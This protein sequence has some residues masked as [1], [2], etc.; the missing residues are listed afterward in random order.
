MEG[1]SPR[2]G[3][4]G[5]PTLVNRTFLCI[6][7]KLA[8]LPSEVLGRVADAIESFSFECIQGKLPP[9]VSEGIREKKGKPE[10][11]FEKANG[12]L[13]NAL[14]CLHMELDCSQPYFAATQAW[15]SESPT[16]NA[17]FVSEL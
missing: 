15:P 8:F 10:G 12:S 14:Q 4:N 9:P 7:I 1:A 16:A 5:R 2:F 3:P 13:A 6:T 11:L 17:L